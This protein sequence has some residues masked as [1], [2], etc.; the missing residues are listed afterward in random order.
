MTMYS[1]IALVTIL[2]LIAIWI[3][4]KFVSFLK[5]RRER[6]SISQDPDTASGQSFET[7]EVGNEIQTK[8]PSQTLGTAHNQVESTT[9][10]TNA[11]VESLR[12]KK[13]FGFTPSMRTVAPIS[14]RGKR[15]AQNFLMLLDT[16]DALEDDESKRRKIHQVYTAASSSGIEANS[17]DET[18]SQ[19]FI[20]RELDKSNDPGQI[21]LSLIKAQET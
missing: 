2:I 17:S 18:A 13:S 3:F 21:Q 4:C 20:G 19:T 12:S 16:L 5:S 15:G 9:T 6:S 8:I 11:S 10:I 1:I 14:N 7:T